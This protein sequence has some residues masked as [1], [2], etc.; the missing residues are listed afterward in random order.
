[1]DLIAEGSPNLNE[2]QVQAAANVVTGIFRRAQYDLGNVSPANITDFASARVNAIKQALTGDQ[3]VTRLERQGLSQAQAT[4]VRTSVTA[5]VN[6]LEQQAN[7]LAQT[8]ETTART[9]ARNA[10]LAWLLGAGLTLL[11][12]VMGARSAATH[13]AIAT[14][15]TDTT[16]R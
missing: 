2:T 4:E 1:M 8:A 10:G 6:R 12:A 5:Q 11:L 14:L 13:R 9:T 3:F 16:R 7:Q 15:P